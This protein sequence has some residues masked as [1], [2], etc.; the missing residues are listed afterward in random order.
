MVLRDAES[1]EQVRMDVSPI[2]YE[3]GK[4]S[5]IENPLKAMEFSKLMD[6]DLKYI[7][8]KLLTYRTGI[9]NCILIIIHSKI[10]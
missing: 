9:T 2:V 1:F 10:F 8:G 7:F 4:I 3:F 6:F 5:S